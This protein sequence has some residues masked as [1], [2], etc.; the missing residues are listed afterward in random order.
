M[1][2]CDSGVPGNQA[3]ITRELAYPAFLVTFVTG[4]RFSP[5]G[6]V[7]HTFTCS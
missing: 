6:Y 3:L 4:N 2:G 1:L 5:E 7:G